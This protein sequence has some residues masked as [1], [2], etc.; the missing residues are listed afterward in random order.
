MLAKLSVLFE[1]KMNRILS[2]F[3]TTRGFK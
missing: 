3:K 2:D 1:P